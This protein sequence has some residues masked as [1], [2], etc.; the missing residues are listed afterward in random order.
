M[1][2]AALVIGGDHVTAFAFGDRRAVFFP[3]VGED[4]RRTTA[5][6][7]VDL[8]PSQQE[9]PTQHKFGD[10]LGMR[11][12]IGQ[13]Q[14]AAPGAAEHLP[15]FD[16]EM[17][18]DALHV[19]H[20]MPSGVVV[21]RGVG[22]AGPTAALV[23]QDNAIGRRV[24]QAAIAPGNPAARPTMHENGRFA[25]RISANFVMDLVSVT[26]IQ[27]ARNAAVDLRIEAPQL[28]HFRSLP[29]FGQR[30]GIPDRASSSAR[31]FSGWPA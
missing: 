20:Q 2:Q 25:L 10:A 24:E 23:E 22:R 8:F 13:R 18:A 26:D 31:S 1:L 19:G 14:G 12:G 16:A 9:N 3:L 27:M 30:P 5:V 6:I 29:I 28:I 15:A 7:P 17:F 11:L 4:R 21:Q